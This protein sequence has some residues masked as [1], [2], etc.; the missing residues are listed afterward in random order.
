MGRYDRMDF[1]DASI[2]VMSEL[3]SRCQ[4]LTVDRDKTPT[5]DERSVDGDPLVA[6][7]DSGHHSS[8]WNHLARSTTIPMTRWA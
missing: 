8:R 6:A 5:L 1:A 3:H 4:V 7:H 2:V